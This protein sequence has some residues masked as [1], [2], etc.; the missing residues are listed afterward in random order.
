MD[1]NVCDLDLLAA[2]AGRG[3]LAAVA[4]LRRELEPQMRRIVHQTL[5]AGTGRTEMSRNILTRARQLAPTAGVVQDRDQLI[6]AVARDLCES[7]INRL[8]VGPRPQCSLQDTVR[9]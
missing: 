7:V 2:R 1:S 4:Q 9:M 3:D 8:R 6:R 5:R